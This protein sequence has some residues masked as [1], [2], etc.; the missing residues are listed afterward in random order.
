MGKNIIHWLTNF[1]AKNLG[2]YLQKFSMSFFNMFDFILFLCG[3]STKKELNTCSVSGRYIGSKTLILTLFSILFLSFHNVNSQRASSRGYYYNNPPVV[4]SPNVVWVNENLAGPVMNIE[5]YDPNPG[6]RLKYYLMNVWDS[7][8]F[9]LDRY[10][11]ELRF[12]VPP[13]Y[14]VPHD[15]DGDN[16]YKIKVKVIDCYGACGYKCIY[17]KV[18]DVDEFSCSNPNPEDDPDGDGIH[19]DCDLDD[20][21]DGVLDVDEFQSLASTI[22][23]PPHSDAVN[24]GLDGFQ[25]FV[26]GSNTNGLGYKESGFQQ[27]VVNQGKSL[28]VLNNLNDFSATRTG[29]GTAI[30]STVNFP[31]GSMRYTSNTSSN[32]AEFKDTTL[33][34]IVS[35]NSGDAAFV[36]PE[37]GMCH[38]NYYKI[39][40][41]FDTSVNAFNIDLTDIFD[42]S[43]RGHYCPPT[44]SYQVY[45]DDKLIAYLEGQTVGSDSTG[46]VKVYDANGSFKKSIKVGHNIE[47]SIGFNTSKL[48]KKVTIRNDVKEGY[49]RN[50]ADHIGLDSF[51]Y[52]TD[53]PDFDKDGIPNHLDLDSDN[54]GIY[55]I[56][57][58]GTGSMDTN[59]DGTID[60]IT[61]TS[62]DTDNDGLADSIEAING[63][64]TG[65]AARETSA[66]TVDYLN[67]DSDD[68]G[69]SDANEAY[70]NRNADGNGDTYYNPSNL[71]EPLTVSSGAVSASGKVVAASYDTGDIAKVIDGS[72]MNSVCNNDTFAVNDFVNTI[73][74][75][76]VTG[77]V[78]TNDYDLQG[79]TQSVK[80][81]PIVNVANGTLTLNPNGDFRYTPNPNFV[82]EDSF[83]YEVCDNNS[84]QSCSRAIVFIEVLPERTTDNEPPIANVDTGTTKMGITL[85]GNVASNDFDPDGDPLTVNTTPVNNVSNGVLTLNANGSFIYVPNAG[86][87]GADTFT[88]Q[89]CDNASPTPLCDTAIVNIIV[90]PATGNI[91]VANDDAYY[92][93]GDT[94]NNNVEGNVLDNDTDPEGHT[95]TVNTTPVSNV[96]NGTLILNENGTFNYQPNAGFFGQDTFRYSVCDNGSPQACD[97]GTVII[98]V[99]K[100]LPPDYKPTLFTGKTIVNGSKA[101]ID[102]VIFVG[103][104]NGQNE[105]GLNP[106]EIRIADSDRFIFQFDATL[107]TLNGTNVDNSDWSYR[108]E[109]GLHK[110]IYVKSGG[111]QGNT[112][113]KIGVK[114]TFNSPEN[115]SGKGPLKVTVKSDSGGQTNTRNDNDQ[116]IIQYTNLVANGNNGNGNGNNG[117]GNN[118]SGYGNG[119]NGNGNGNNGNGNGNGNNGNG[120]NGNGY[121]NGNNGNGNGN[122]GNGNGNGGNSDD[123]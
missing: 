111:F 33:Q 21:N 85:N 55:D 22:N 121:G 27:A 79:D 45:A 20:D 101:K 107:T 96:N 76:L 18:K 49:L 62:G 74:G 48:V 40:I 38:N 42:I 37:Y 122:N 28:V 67:A 19:N 114:A 7:H 29:P 75:Q 14:E 1:G 113:S 117:N 43:V 120:N 93:V 72:S 88:Y 4:T 46:Y 52:S 106:V 26:I 110:F 82:G 92:T 80:S 31:N 91:T 50:V 36:V 95:Q 77:N 25:I 104:A 12:I 119:N 94:A 23:N 73:E 60:S 3:R 90:T 47:A 116:D 58:A 63:Q 13:D 30:H 56:V 81:D 105:N 10:S 112:V 5:A 11:G 118:G 61:S 44:L 2:E 8:H 109:S 65:T 71:A 103:E 51:V 15:S 123:D 32:Y 83:T 89:I 24:W 115:S 78:L 97:I 108:K 17:I 54:D 16:R 70:N 68:D 99:D 100:F 41:D 64:N 39:E 6:G 87:I 102:F 84:A 35:G 69:C 98:L 53:F 34:N 9:T 59:N 66:G 86:F 57:E